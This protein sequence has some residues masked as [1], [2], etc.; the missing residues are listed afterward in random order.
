MYFYKDDGN[1]LKK[2]KQKYDKTFDNAK[3]RPNRRENINERVTPQKG[4]SGD[5][6]GVQILFDLRHLVSGH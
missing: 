5:S 1:K 6:S 4:R 3:F 2:K